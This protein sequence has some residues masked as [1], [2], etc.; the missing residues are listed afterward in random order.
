MSTDQQIVLRIE[1]LVAGAITAGLLILVA[2]LLGPVLALVG[3]FAV[4]LVLSILLAL[5]PKAGRRSPES[6]DAEVRTQFTY[7]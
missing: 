6:A 2:V 1:T 5:G 4:V 3:F 7:R